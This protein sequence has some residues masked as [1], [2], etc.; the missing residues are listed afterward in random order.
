MIARTSAMLA[1]GLLSAAAA[2]AGT[3]VTSPWD[4][5]ATVTVRY[6]D[7]DLSSDK[8]ATTLYQRIYGAARQVCPSASGLSFTAMRIRD[9]CISTAVE[10]AV[11][12]VNSPT[13]AKVNAVRSK[14]LAQS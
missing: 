12:E 9:T 11:S 7:L 3:P 10:R 2:M 5:T 13:L 14:R 1:V 4:E 6:D 8:G